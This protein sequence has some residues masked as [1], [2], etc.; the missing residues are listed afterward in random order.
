M[1]KQIT[2]QTP[3]QRALAA[4]AAMRANAKAAVYVPP[5]NRP[6]PAPAKADATVARK[7]DMAK[8]EVAARK[9]A[10][11]GKVANAR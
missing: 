7:A 9:A 1:A 5:S 10:G 11:K 8:R 6:T 2:T 3:E 4:I